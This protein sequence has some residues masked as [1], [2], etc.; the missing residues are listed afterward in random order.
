[1]FKSKVST[2]SHNGVQEAMEERSMPPSVD[3]APDPEVVPKAKR[4]KFTKRDKL[5]ILKAADGCTKPGQLGALLRSE[6]V[7]SSYLTRWRQ[8]LKA[9]QLATKKRGRPAE[10]PSL[11]ELARLRRENARLAKKLEQ[12]E[13]IIDVQKKLSDL[14]GLQSEATGKG[15]DK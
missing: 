5:R 14:L 1:M 4:R 3:Q 6:G 13:V 2:P 7:Y 15:E 11:K 12:A 8:Q 9:G 10:D